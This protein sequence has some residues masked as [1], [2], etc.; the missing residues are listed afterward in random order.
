VSVCGS[1]FIL[2]FTYYLLYT[3][4]MPLLLLKEHLIISLVLL[5]A[6]I[7]TLSRIYEHLYIDKLIIKRRISFFKMLFLF[8][9]FS[10]CIN[11][12]L[13][14]FVISL[15]LKFNFYMGTVALVSVVVLFILTIHYIENQL[16]YQ[17]EQL[18]HKNNILT[19]NEQHYRSLFENNP[20][21]VFTLDLAGNF[22]AVNASV[23][24]L[25]NLTLE[26]LLQLTLMDLLVEEEKNKMMLIL[27]DVYNGSNA[28]FETIM[29]TKGEKTVNL[30]V[31]A[32][33][34]NINEK[35]TGAYFIAQDITKQIEMQNKVRFLAYHDELTGLL[36]RR[37]IYRKV[38]NYIHSRTLAAAILIDI[39]M[40]KDIND[41]LGHMA[42]DIFLQQVANRLHQVIETK[43][44]IGRMG[45]D[46]F[47][48][49][50]TETQ[51]KWEVIEI[52]QEIQTAMEEPFKIQESIKEITLSIGVSYFPEDGEDFNTLIKHA[53]MAM[54]KAKKHGRNNFVEYSSDLEEEKL[55][56][57]TMLQE[58]KLAI[59]QEQFHLNFQPKHS[60]NDNKVVGIE[61]LVRWQHPSKG[62]ISPVKFIPLA[63]QNGLII[64]ISNWIIQEACRI[65]SQWIQSYHVSFHLSINVSPAHFLDNGFI[66]FLIKQAEKYHI[67]TS[68]IDI[69][70]T[71]N[72]AI[73]NT[74]LT[75]KKINILKKKGFQ[76]SMD[77]F[78]T[79][80]TS[81]T[82]LSQFNL[83]R[84]KIDRSF[85]MELPDNRNNGAI[86]ESLISVAKNLDM[87]V[88]A[89]GVETEAQLKI[90]NKWGCDEIQGY[91]F[92]KPLPAEELIE[93][94]KKQVKDDC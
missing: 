18:E 24:P 56:Q 88:T 13:Y 5:I 58:L 12:S 73:E 19:I 61:T 45:G 21:A 94:W 81:L 71:E 49:C 92:S 85:I 50:M 52:L 23:L 16:K 79:G 7:Y 63:E 83:D 48:I 20:D 43:G 68:M 60:S 64:P 33:P 6:A 28:S 53:D 35:I 8:F 44:L 66:D 62:I 86:V 65:Y 82:Y 3:L 87:I 32:L 51:G 55:N 26:E 59:N 84:I 69:E 89:E 91:Y 22:I 76:I 15:L 75:R 67:P 77:D 47:L 11:S 31:T 27:K 10:I 2:G 42:G 25:T 29:R 54:Y 30:K 37:G 93:Y 14:I 78:G 80:Y 74:E 90:L 39:D 41:H 46:E 70:I 36:N 4:K 57:I 38:E 17:Q 72:L 34:I 9:M 40:F 1:I